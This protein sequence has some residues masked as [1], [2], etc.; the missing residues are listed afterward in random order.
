MPKKKMYT[1]NVEKKEKLPTALFALEFQVAAN[2]LVSLGYRN[3]E[4]LF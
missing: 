4:I 1:S 3:H 2:L